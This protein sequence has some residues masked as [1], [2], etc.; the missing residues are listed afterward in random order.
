MS[1]KNREARVRIAKYRE[2]I[3]K[4]PWRSPQKVKGACGAAIR[5]SAEEA[6]MADR[7]SGQNR[8]CR[9]FRTFSIGQFMSVA[10]RP[11]NLAVR[12]ARAGDAKGPSAG[13][14]AIIRKSRMVPTIRWYRTVQPQGNKEVSLEDCRAVLIDHRAGF[15]NATAQATEQVAAQFTAQV[16]APLNKLLKERS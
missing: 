15:A 13:H 6:K 2:E 16:P 14:A 10:D 7:T 12:I 11:E 5:L 4:P 3:A 1:G 8:N 9:I